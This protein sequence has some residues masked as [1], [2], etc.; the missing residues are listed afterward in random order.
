MLR[1]TIIAAVVLFCSCTAAKLSVPD[2]FSSQATKMHVTGLNGWMI[3]QELSFGNYQTSRI[4]RGWDFE[5]SLQ[6]TK[7][8]IRPEE[9]SNEI[10]PVPSPSGDLLAAFTTYKDDVDLVLFNI[11]E[12][13]MLKNLTSGYTSEYEYAIVQSFTTGPVMGRDA[14]CAGD[15]RRFSRA[16]RARPRGHALPDADRVRR[17]DR[18]VPGVFR[19]ADGRP[20]RD[21]S[22]RRHARHRRHV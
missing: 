21:A 19:R 20:A 5:G 15:R 2:Q 1:N 12:R 9:Q 6:W 17:G 10:A 22:R 18:R 11:P 14:A 13:R 4:K 8:R 16:V 7:F 3:N